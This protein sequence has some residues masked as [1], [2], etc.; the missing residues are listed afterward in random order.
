MKKILAMAVLILSMNAMAY[1][2]QEESYIG[3]CGSKAQLEELFQGPLSPADLKEIK[4]QRANI[5]HVLKNGQKGL[6]DIIA[7]GDRTD[8]G[9]FGVLVVCGVIN[10]IKNEIKAD[11]CYDLKTNKPVRDNGGIAVCTAA[12]EK[13]EKKD[14]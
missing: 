3:F 12:M 11:G 2:E 7:E 5:L 9:G 13:L 14:K 10:Q 4:A 6:Q 1:T 8:V